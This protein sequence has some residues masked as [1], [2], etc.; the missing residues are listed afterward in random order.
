MELRSIQYEITYVRK[1]IDQLKCRKNTKRNEDCV[2]VK[3]KI[4]MYIAAIWSFFLQKND[5]HFMIS[6][7][8][9]HLKKK[10]LLLDIVNIFFIT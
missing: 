4:V 7:A 6:I 9:G 1:K 10:C 2:A 3:K 8:D 5:F